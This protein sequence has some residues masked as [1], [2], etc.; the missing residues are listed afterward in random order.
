MYVSILH[1]NLAIM[2]DTEHRGQERGE[3]P[4]SYPGGLNS[5]PDPEATYSDRFV[6]ISLRTQIRACTIF[7]TPLQNHYLLIMPLFG[8]VYSELLILSLNKLYIQILNVPFYAR[9]INLRPI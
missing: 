5:N 1:F 4:A 6:M 9:C 7:S 8:S 3:P 2:K